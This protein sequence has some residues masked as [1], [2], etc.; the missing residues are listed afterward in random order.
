MGY[1]IHPILF[2]S[3]KKIKRSILMSKKEKGIRKL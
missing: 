3:T 1:S 2:L